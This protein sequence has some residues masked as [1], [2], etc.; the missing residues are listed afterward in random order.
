MTARVEVMVDEEKDA[1]L[2]PVEA[3]FQKGGR[4]MSYIVNKHGRV[5]EREIQTDKN[6]EDFVVVKNG[7]S[8]GERVLL[9]DPSK[10]LNTFE[11]QSDSRS[12]AVPAATTESPK[13]EE[14]KV[15]P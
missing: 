14:K 11:K 12:T 5:E 13:P 2:V 3:V 6:N 8:E 4:K 10:E 1:L 15:V 9:L 7:L